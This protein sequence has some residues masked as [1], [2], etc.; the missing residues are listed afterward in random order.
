VNFDYVKL[1]GDLSDE[2]RL[3]FY[4]CLAHNLTVSARAIWSDENLTDG[5][6]VEQLKWLN[7]IMHRVTM[8]SAL[9]R[10]HKNTFSE[11]DSWE[12]IRHWVSCCGD[13]EPPV[14]WALKFSYDTCRR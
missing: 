2:E 14:E 10:T 7:E 4:E 6:K 9:L 8:K 3:R 11:S 12:S 13:I 1:I 5:R